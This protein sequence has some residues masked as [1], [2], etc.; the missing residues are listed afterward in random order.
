M[1]LPGPVAPLASVV[2]PDGVWDTYRPHVHADD[3][4]PRFLV[5]AATVTSRGL[6]RA[7]RLD[8]L[9]PTVIL[10]V[11]GDFAS[12]VSPVERVEVIA[13]RGRTQRPGRCRI[14]AVAGPAHQ[15]EGAL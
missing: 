13:R 4:W 10:V 14:A 12:H 8:W 7:P 5:V 9:P 2:R 15:G 1:L 3:A 11:P 6:L